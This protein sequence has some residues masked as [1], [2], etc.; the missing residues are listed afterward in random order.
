MASKWTD[1]GDEVQDDS[2]ISKQGPTCKMCKLLNSLTGEAAEE[3]EKA[4]VSVEVTS[5]SIRRA[6]IA[7][8]DQRQVPSAYSIARHRRGDCRRGLKG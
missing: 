7:R 1:F 5:T 8:V 2:S 4:C 6:L 3:I